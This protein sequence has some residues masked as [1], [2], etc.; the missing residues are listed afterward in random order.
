MD[1]CKIR[2]YELCTKYSLSIDWVTKEYDRI[3]HHYSKKYRAYHNLTHLEELFKQ[4]DLYATKLRHDDEVAFAIFY[5]DI[6]YKIG[7]STNETDSAILCENALQTVNF[8]KEAIQRIGDLIRCTQHH[9]AVTND[10]KWIIDFD[11]SILGQTEEV[12]QSY[13]QKIRKEY[14]KI[15]GMIYR[16]GRIK[17]LQ[18]FLDKA[19][20]F[21]TNQF[22]I[23]YEN[24]ARQ[25]LKDELEILKHG[26]K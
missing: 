10:E 13:V 7:S 3:E 19:T 17:V 8:E 6:I 26:T 15:P 25:N 14:R 20:I 9:N 12:Y 11:L 4:F 23:Q 16:K 5:H 24:Q 21:Q 1:N 2:F 22:R 18:H